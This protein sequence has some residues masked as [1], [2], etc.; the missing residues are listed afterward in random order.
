MQQPEWASGLASG[1]ALP[2]TPIVQNLRRG[3]YDIGERAARQAAG[4]AVAGSAAAVQWAQIRAAAPQIAAVMERYLQRL[5]AFLA[6]ASVAA[7][8]NALRQLARWMITDAGL[9][10]IAAV[11]RDDIEDY[12]VWLADQR[13]AGGATIT[14]ETH[15]QRM[16]TV[17]QFFERIIDWDWRATGIRVPATQ[18]TPPMIWWSTVI[19]SRSTRSSCRLVVQRRTGPHTSCRVSPVV[20]RLLERPGR[21]A[22]GP[23]VHRSHARNWG[24]SCGGRGSLSSGK[25]A[26][27]G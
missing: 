14:A 20:P 24:T 9:G 23:A 25:G 27:P 5:G 16:R 2:T 3:H 7:A 6:P 21:R 26:P 18:G 1:S 13:G 19:R 8:E 4:R 17:R 12:K 10:S 22:A 11:R 15:R